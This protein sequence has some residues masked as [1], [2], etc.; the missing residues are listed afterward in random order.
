M[1][2]VIRTPFKG[3]RSQ[4]GGT[5]LEAMV[6]LFVLAIGLMGM[7]SLQV[8]AVK[9]SQ[10]ADEY[11]RA[12][13]LANELMEIM[14]VSKDAAYFEVSSKNDIPGVT[15]GSVPT[16]YG[17]SVYCSKSQSLD[18]QFSQWGDKLIDE[19]PTADLVITVDSATIN[20][21]DTEMATIVLSFS[22]EDRTAGYN[23]ESVG[24][25]VGIAKRSDITIQAYL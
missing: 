13:F 7:F 19:L 14:L 11:T 25:I 5:M 17:E 3:P 2:P 22:A 23:S 18:Y 6:A 20:G 12:S 4:F 8:K 16:C 21:V 9:G 15:G 1:A 10:T 24:S